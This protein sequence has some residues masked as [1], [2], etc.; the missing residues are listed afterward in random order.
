MSGMALFMLCTLQKNALL[1]KLQL[2]HPKP[3]FTFFIAVAKNF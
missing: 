1:I 2:Q 3:G